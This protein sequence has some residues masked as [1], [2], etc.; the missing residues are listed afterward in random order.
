MHTSPP[1]ASWRKF[2]YDVGASLA[3]AV[4]LLVAWA[5][6]KLF[7]G[8]AVSVSELVLSLLAIGG[9]LV[10]FAGFR[11]WSYFRRRREAIAAEVWNEIRQKIGIEGVYKGISACEDEI[12]ALIRQAK[13]TR[14]YLQIGTTVLSGP[15]TIFQF[16]EELSLTPNASIRIMHAS[17]S[18]PYLS[19][20]VARRRSSKDSSA[21]WLKWRDD[22]Q[23]AKAQLAALRRRY[24]DQVKVREHEEPFVWRLF[25]MDDIAFIQPYLFESNNSEKANVLRVV[26]HRMRPGTEGDSQSLYETVSRYFE[27]M[28]DKYPPQINSLESLI[29]PDAPVTVA[30]IVRIGECYLFAVPI[31]NLK[32]SV[33]PVEFHLPGG[34]PQLKEHWW[35]ALKRELEEE[36]GVLVRVR[37]SDATIFIDGDNPPANVS[38]TDKPSP[39]IARKRIRE[40]S[41]LWTLGYKA[42]VRG[43]AKPSP[44]AET[45][46]LLLLSPQLLQ[47]AKQ[48]RLTFEHIRQ[49]TDGSR[50]VLR[51]DVTVD[52]SRRLKPG[53][54]APF[55][56]LK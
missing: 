2:A 14:I 55:L 5:I 9:A 30:G 41:T 45:A 56:R 54:L 53:G 40:G 43:T 44:K 26:Q 3:G 35:Q 50:L 16:L 17:A 25:L 47:D 18:S 39:R 27:A 48:E 28:W 8:E 7:L 51:S 52:S 4:V 34:K 10:G 19:P 29:E 12:K 31:R 46:A 49:A 21:K 24:G 36:L 1:S 23:H 11:L 33:S 38:L 6:L 32:D 37:H 42:V 22:I 13:D 15:R 20:A